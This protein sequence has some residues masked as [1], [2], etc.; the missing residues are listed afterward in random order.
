M[1][2]REPSPPERLRRAGAT[3]LERRLLDAASREQPS[4]ELSERMARGIGIALPVGGSVLPAQNQAPGATGGGSLA[5]K[6]VPTSSSLVPWVAGTILAA[7]VVIGVVVASRPSAG[8]RPVATSPSPA[9]PVVPT[10]TTATSANIPA[11]PPAALVGTGA[12]EG[13]RAS[14]LASSQRGRESATANAL[15]DELALV[16]AAHR[17]LSDGDAAGALTLAR[18]YSAEYPKG[19]FRPEAAAIRIEALVKLGRS[20]EARR[21][22]DKFAASYG[23]GPLADRIAGLVGA[24]QH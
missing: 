1:S 21:L 5:A 6:A 9:L 17:A 8:P 16:D 14:P 19:T 15:S 11:E 22:A 23:P 18:K 24:S 7:A 12:A 2:K 4:R 3:E 20:A 10:A 13:V